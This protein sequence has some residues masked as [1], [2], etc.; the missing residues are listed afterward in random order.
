MDIDKNYNSLTIITIAGFVDKNAIGNYDI[1]RLNH[2]IPI[3]EI[4]NKS[5]KAKEIR[6]WIR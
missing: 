2:I 5:T 1:L 4:G 3:C 6:T